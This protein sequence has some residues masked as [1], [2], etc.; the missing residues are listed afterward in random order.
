[1][2]KG[3]SGERRQGDISLFQ[4]HARLAERKEDIP[5]LLRYFLNEYNLVN[6]YKVEGF[7][8]EVMICLLQYDWPGNV[9][10]LRTVLETALAMSKTGV[11]QAADLHL[12]EEPESVA[13]PGPGS[14]NLAVVEAWA[15]RLALAETNGNN[16]QAARLLGIHR[17][18][19]I[20]KLKKIPP[21]QRA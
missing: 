20:N 10:Q 17:D 19:L 2:T 16:T 11:L 8:P 3:C 7:T 13:R 1:M 21:E 12:I 15:I 14:L 5:H 9:R 18:T 4:V 6:G